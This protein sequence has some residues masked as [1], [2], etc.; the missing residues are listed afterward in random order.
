MLRAN[1]VA[2]VT[3]GSGSAVHE[4]GRTEDED[5]RGSSGQEMA[6]LMKGLVS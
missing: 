4:E 6:A 5:R 2:G 1:E 3:R